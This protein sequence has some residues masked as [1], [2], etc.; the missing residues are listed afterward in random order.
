MS[1]TSSAACGP[2][3][4]PLVRERKPQATGETTHL[5]KS[6]HASKHVDQ[7]I[8]PCKIEFKA[9]AVLATAVLLEHYL[10]HKPSPVSLQMGPCATTRVTC[11]S[12]FKWKP[13]P[14]T[15]VSAVAC[16]ALHLQRE[17][18]LWTIRAHSR[19]ECWQQPTFAGKSH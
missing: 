14:E 6:P 13:S 4:C 12:S 5:A 3:K 9:T 11:S 17:I 18:G 8:N 7:P 2:I 19:Y 16:T 1:R 15:L 10:S